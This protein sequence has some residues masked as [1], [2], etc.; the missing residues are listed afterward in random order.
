MAMFVGR[1]VFQVGKR[2]RAGK[3]S[4]RGSKQLSREEG[5]IT[6]NR[7][8]AGMVGEG[9]GVLEV[10]TRGRQGKRRGGGILPPRAK[11]VVVGKAALNGE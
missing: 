6:E 3:Q 10:G 11:K 4:D 8:A 5:E 2:K 9:E 1:E 7:K